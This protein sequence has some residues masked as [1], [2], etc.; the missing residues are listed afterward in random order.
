MLFLYFKKGVEIL[1]YNIFQHVT[2]PISGF[3]RPPLKWFC[4]YLKSLVF[5]DFR[6]SPLRGKPDLK[7]LAPGDLRKTP[8]WAAF[9][10]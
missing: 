1:K 10:C 9:F 6:M 4:R 7:S 8:K 2:F 3:Q 5:Q